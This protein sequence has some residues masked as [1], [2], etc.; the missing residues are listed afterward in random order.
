[1][2]LRDPKSYYTQEDLRTLSQAFDL[3]C[4]EIG[5]C[6]GDEGARECLAVL[7]FDVARTGVMDGA[8]LHAQVV[9]RFK[10]TGWGESAVPH[11]HISL[12]VQLRVPVQPQPRSINR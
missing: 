3:A 8:M 4:S 12:A 1:M 5:L 7:I 11:A 9:D 6:P 10:A 2:A